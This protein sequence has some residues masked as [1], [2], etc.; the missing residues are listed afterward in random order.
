MARLVN[1]DATVERIDDEAEDAG[2][3]GVTSVGGTAGAFSLIGAAIIPLQKSLREKR[4]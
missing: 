4:R 2:E 3:G 1:G